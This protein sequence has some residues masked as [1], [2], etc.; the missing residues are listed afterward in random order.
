MWR[1]TLDSALEPE[2]ELPKYTS[3]SSE[4]EAPADGRIWVRLCVNSNIFVPLFFSNLNI[5]IT[6][7]V[8]GSYQRYNGQQHTSEQDVDTLAVREE[9]VSMSD[10]PRIEMKGSMLRKSRIAPRFK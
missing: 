8:N 1:T 2:D 6:P 10:A 5:D 4:I 9:S 7:R 3:M